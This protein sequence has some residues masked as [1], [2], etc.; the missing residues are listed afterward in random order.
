MIKW[1]YKRGVRRW[2][3]KQLGE[4]TDE[5]LAERLAVSRQRETILKKQS[6]IVD[7]ILTTPGGKQYKALQNERK[8]LEF[9]IDKLTAKENR[10]AARLDILLAEAKR[11]KEQL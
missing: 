1:L 7:T 5:L 9:D 10:I 8:A 6:R 11:R 2:T 4:R 3:D